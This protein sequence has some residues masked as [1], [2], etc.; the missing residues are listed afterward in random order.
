MRDMR[1][2]DFD[3]EQLP[4]EQDTVPP[5]VPDYTLLQDRP[6]M[7]LLTQVSQVVQQIALK[8]EQIRNDQV[9]SDVAF[10]WLMI[11]PQRQ[12]PLP[13]EPAYLMILDKAQQEVKNAIE[14]CGTFG[15]IDEIIITTDTQLN[16]LLDNIILDPAEMH[17]LI[18]LQQ[19]LYL[20]QKQ[21]E[22]FMQELQDFQK[23]NSLPA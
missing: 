20:Q 11:F 17:Q 3:D 5:M 2:D 22:L 16:G 6:S 4:P 7:K 15:S 14:W 12:L 8:L 13:A 9:R 23:E 21:L 1:E 18:I 19:D 10:Y